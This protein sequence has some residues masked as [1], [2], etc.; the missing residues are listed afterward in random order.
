[1]SFASLRAPRG[2]SLAPAPLVALL[3]ATHASALTSTVACELTT[4]PPVTLEVAVGRAPSFHRTSSAPLFP[5]RDEPGQTAS[6]TEAFDRPYDAPLCSG[7]RVAALAASTDAASS[8]VTL[9]G[10]PAET[11]A[12][13]RQGDRY[14]DRVVWFVGGDRAWLAG[15][16]GLCQAT[17]R[18]A[19]APPPV[20]AHAPAAPGGGLI[21]RIERRGPDEVVVDRATL[22]ALIAEL[23]TLAR[24]VRAT[25]D[26]EG[27]RTVGLRLSG[28]R[29]GDP[30]AAFGLE[31]GDRIERIDGT[32]LAGP[33]TAIE[34]YARARVRDHVS[35]VVRRGAS[36]RTVELQIR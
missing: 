16:D 20:L 23:P 9:E 33:D 21:A 22:E 28:I 26:Q 18:G 6:M 7:V 8:F 13:R 24:G 35:I 14:R 1:M 2:W 5:S 32:E 29:P 3:A 4:A 15:A 25:F 11:I 31:T 34:A 17:L 27:G 30:L 12:P 10:D 19:P 36:V